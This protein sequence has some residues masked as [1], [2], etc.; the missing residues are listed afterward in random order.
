MAMSCKFE[1][2]CHELV[3]LLQSC[4]LAGVKS[5]GLANE[6]HVCSLCKMSV[7]GSY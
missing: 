3:L 4:L 6:N 5:L 1:Q 2:G 7:L